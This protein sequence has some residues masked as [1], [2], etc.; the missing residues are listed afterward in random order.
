MKKET[1]TPK[2][3]VA[4]AKAP[5]ESWLKANG[6][7]VMPV[8]FGAAFAVFAFIMLVGKNSDY[9]WGV[10]DRTIFLDSDEFFHERMAVPGGF[11]AW[12]GC[13]LA[14][15][16]YYPALGALM[17][18]GLWL[19]GYVLTVQTF[20][21]KGAW[22]ALALIPV[23]ALLASEIDIAYWIY[24]LKIPGYWFRET[25]GFVV[26]MWALW[27][28]AKLFSIKDE[29]RSLVLLSS[30]SLYMVVFAIAGYL[31]LSWW[32]LIGLIAMAIIGTTARTGRKFCFYTDS[33]WLLALVLLIFVPK[34]AYGCYSQFRIED[35]WT[36]G[37]PLFQNDQLTSLIMSVPFAIAALMVILL[38]SFYPKDGQTER[39][40]KTSETVSGIIIALLCGLGV[41]HANIDDWNYHSELRMHR[42]VT[43]QRWDDVLDEAASNPGEPTREIVLFKNLALMYKGQFGYKFTSYNN[44]GIAPAQPDSLQVHLVQTCGP[45]LYM[46]Y[47][48]EN[49]ATRWSIENEVEYGLSVT[50]AKT[51]TLAALIAG[52]TKLA[53]KYIELLKSTT[54]HKEWAEKYEPLTDNIALVGDSTKYPEFAFTKEIYDHCGSVLDGDEGLVELYLL[55]YFSHTQNKDSKLLNEVTLNFACICKDIQLFWPRFFLYANL[56]QGEPM[57]RIYQEAAFLYGNLEHE[58]DISK[59]PFDED[60][61]TRY[62]GFQQM[63]QSLLRQGMDASQVGEAMKAAYGDNFWWF[64]FFCRDVK[65]Y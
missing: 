10:Q 50:G 19:I 30:K 36:V 4:P 55:N 7:W 20:R 33:W 51:L 12:A 38:A 25:I 9:L 63:S 11:I 60:I 57:P 37:F 53:K 29:K 48:K 59:M 31:L 8:V 43:E 3:A 49:F 18:I 13:Y 62:N 39:K 26:M 56:H 1:K 34:V 14:Q 24:Y 47:G 42:A 6:Q 17:L 52:E 5:K 46:N 41:W 2:V 23:C 28:W 54:F 16:F 27:G 58:V 44:G 21:L 15:Y 22:S 32:S 45:I 65:S 61:K 35:A 64:Y 40:V